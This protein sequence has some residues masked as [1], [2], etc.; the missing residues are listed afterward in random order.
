ML[1]VFA[2][3]SAGW[4]VDERPFWRPALDPALL[5]SD[6]PRNADGVPRVPGTA[7]FWAAVFGDSDPDRDRGGLAD[8]PPVEFIWLCEQIFTGGQAVVRGPYQQL[9]FVARRVTTLTREGARDA[10]VATRAAIQFPALI[11]AL[12]RARID[13]IPTYAAAAR[14][15]AYRGDR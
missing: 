12:E 1:A 6:L 7:A 9:L 2:R 10:V 8:G 3:V 11:T 14:R 5:V 13:A 15:A 4:D